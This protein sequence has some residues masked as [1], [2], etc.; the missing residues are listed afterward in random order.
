MAAMKPDEGLLNPFENTGAVSC[1]RLNFPRPEALAQAAI[2]RSMTDI[3]IRLR[4]T[5][6]VGAPP[7]V[8]KVTDLVD[9]IEKRRSK[10]TGQGS[11]RS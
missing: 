6:K 1:W 2:L 8:S 3:I 9:G 7:F 10:I 5:A 4:F 11:A